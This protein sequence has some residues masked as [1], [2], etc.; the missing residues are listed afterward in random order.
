MSIYQN[1]LTHILWM[2][3]EPMFYQTQMPLIC[4]IL[5]SDIGQCFRPAQKKSKTKNVRIIWD[6]GILSQ[7]IHLLNI[8]G[9]TWAGVGCRH[10]T[11]HR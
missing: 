9:S 11:D 3:G 10:A 7:I 6:K 5:F 4:L 2:F 8:S 1:V